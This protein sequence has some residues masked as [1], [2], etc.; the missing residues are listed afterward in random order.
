MARTYFCASC[1]W[2][3]CTKTDPGRCPECGRLTQRYQTTWDGVVSDLKKVFAFCAVFVSIAFIG[4]WL[5]YP[6]QIDGKNDFTARFPPR[7]WNRRL[8][9]ALSPRL[10]GQDQNVPVPFPQNY[11]IRHIGK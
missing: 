8:E 10:V 5:T 9:S 6:Y 3:G 2:K 7:Y 4:T 1:G 11:P